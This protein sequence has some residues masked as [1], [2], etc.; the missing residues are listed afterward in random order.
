MSLT[1]FKRFRME[2]RLPGPF[3]A[4]LDP[5]GLFVPSL[6]GVLVRGPCGSQVQQLQRR[7]RRQRVPLPGRSGRLSAADGGD[8]AAGGFC[9]GGDM[10]AAVLA[11]RRAAA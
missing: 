3:S 2:I 9:E 10:A 8:H 6:A 7:N 5:R 11:A 1:Y 4:A